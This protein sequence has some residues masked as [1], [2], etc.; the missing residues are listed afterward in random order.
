MMDEM[1]SPPYEP[2]PGISVCPTGPTQENPG[3]IPDEHPG[4]EGI[5]MPPTAP[6]L[7]MPTQEER[8]PLVDLGT[9]TDEDVREACREF[10]SENCCYG[11]K[12]I[13][14]TQLPEIF[15]GCIY[16][17]QLETF[18]E[19]RETVLRQEP[20]RGQYIDGPENGPPPP[21]WEMLVP[22]PY[23]FQ[24]CQ[25]KVEI[26]HTAYVKQCSRCVGNC[27]VRCESCY[28]RGG[29]S[30]W[31]CN[32]MGRSDGQQ[33]TTCYG[34][35]RRRCW[36]CSGTGQVKCGTCDGRGNCR[37]YRLLI[38]TWQNHVESYITHT[39]K[40][41]KHLILEASGREIFKEESPVVFP[42]NHA[43]DDSVNEASKVMIQKHS[44]AFPN[45]LIRKQRHNLRA[46]PLVRAT[47]SWKN[48]QGEFY[49]YGFQKKVHFEDYPQKCCCCTCC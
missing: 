31:S 4:K 15:N 9:L 10:A 41:P 16:H 39:F 28:G 5:V 33:C 46:V 18:G 45:E 48:K 47:Y 49:V 30:C 23:L 34:T 14:D 42:I 8:M 12:F 40:L 32:G 43:R 27:R 24:D 7:E 38:V 6:P 29:S 17:Y 26:P 25:A 2:I 19:K 36:N 37:H 11:T 35:G 20:F 1:K 21:P 13:R 3:F 44:T 22:I